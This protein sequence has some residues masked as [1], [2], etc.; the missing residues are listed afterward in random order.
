[1][2]HKIYYSK[3]QDDVYLSSCSSHDLFSFYAYAK[4]TDGRIVRY[5]EMCDGEPSGKWD[6]YIF[7][8]E[9]DWYRSSDKLLAGPD[10]CNFP[11]SSAAEAGDK[12]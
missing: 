8:G 9:G 2:T 6:D 1:M 7:L 10:I 12:S 3:K 5:T 11:G 4:L